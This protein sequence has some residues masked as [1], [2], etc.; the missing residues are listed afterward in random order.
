MTL[1]HHGYSPMN[2]V[3]EEDVEISKQFSKF[4]C[5]R[6]GIEDFKVV[7]EYFKN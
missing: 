3:L 1:M 6:L 2:D 7:T 4:N 5:K